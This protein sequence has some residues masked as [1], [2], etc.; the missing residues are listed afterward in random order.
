MIAPY[1]RIACRNRSPY[2]TSQFPGP[3]PRAIMATPATHGAANLERA[4][5]GVKQ[6]SAVRAWLFTVAALVFLMI[7][8]GGATRLTDSGLSITEWKPILGAIPPLSDADWQAAFAKYKEIPEYHHVNKGM[9]LGEFKEIFWWEWAHRFLGRFIGLAFALPLAVFW[10]GGYL[11]PGFAA[12][13]SGVLAL[14]ALQGAMGW[15]MVMSGLVDR[16]DVSQYR[17]AAHLVIAILIFALVLWL[18]F[19]LE[20]T[21]AAR[22]MADPATRRRAGFLVGL[23][24]L[25]VVLGA[26]VAGLKAGLAYNTWPLMDGAVVPDGLFRLEPWYLNFFENETMV[27][28]NHR[29]AAYA[30]AGFTLWHVWRTVRS[31]A[32]DA[33]SNSAY[34]LLAAV[35]A[36]VVI[37]ILTLL[38]AVPIGL[39]LAHQAGAAIVVAFA[40]RHLHTLRAEAR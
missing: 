20:E 17:L 34:W 23:I 21:R 18:A 6:D 11:R 29:L 32:P 7:V 3:V 40:V 13:L 25:Q 19:E 22:A 39:G 30:V 38:A 36:Q 24:F 27:Q 16:V 9:S 31:G 8:V 2:H 26:L 10:L 33:V 35:F 15:Y 12:K 14:G 4:P 37:G 1:R 28:F 5:S